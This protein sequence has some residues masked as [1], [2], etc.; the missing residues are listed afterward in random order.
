MAPHAHSP[1]YSNGKPALTS[2]YPDIARAFNDKDVQ[3]DLADAC[4]K[5]AKA[6]ASLMSKFDTIATQ[7]HTFDMQRQTA[8]MSPQWNNMRRDFQQLVWQTRTNAGFIS[9]RLK[10]FCTAVIPL[11]AQNVND[12]P[13]Q[14]LNE[15]KL[16]VV[17][18]YMSISADNAKLT[19]SLIGKTLQFGSALNAFHTEIA[20]Y[21]SQKH[22]AGKRDLRELVQKLSELDSAVQQVC[23]ANGRLTA[24]DVA[25]IAFAAF[26]VVAST[27]RRP[28]RSKICH[29]RVVLRED[30]SNVGNLYDQ[31]D[32]I[33]NEV[34]HAHYTVQTGPARTGSL[35]SNV[36]T[37]IASLVSDL[38]QTSES[39]LSLFLAIWARLQCDCAE[40]LHWLGD[41]LRGTT[42]HGA[43][44]ICVSVY[45]E[46]AKTV[47]TGL[48]NALEV[49]MA[50]YD[51]SWF[52]Q[53][54]QK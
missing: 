50:S 11:L 24:P 42:K 21:A 9:G 52:T 1:S 6:T 20:K 54:H 28:G 23:A 43:I 7:L 32:R 19:C 22:T 4:S 41:T 31:L 3:A 12:K 45:V 51:P 27:I 37:E 26:R 49:L 30:L 36:Q 2:T 33:R 53:L 13:N 39:I 18:S 46:N 44:P 5:L 34:A 40:I 10:M 15:E 17:Q 35:L 47:Y 8:P 38:L 48:A 16:Q 14:R 25:H 29:Q